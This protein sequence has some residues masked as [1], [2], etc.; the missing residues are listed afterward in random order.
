M[1]YRHRRSVQTLCHHRYAAHCE[2]N[3]SHRQCRLGFLR[4]RLS[5]A[6]D[7]ECGKLVWRTDTVPGDPAQPSIPKPW[8]PAK[9]WH[10]QWWVAGGGGTPWDTIVYDPGL[11]FVYVGTGNGTAWYRDQRSP[12]AATT[13]I[14]PPFSPCAR[15]RGD[16]LTLP[17]NAGRKP[18][19]R[20][21]PALNDGRPQFFRHR[22]Q[23]DHPG[24]EERILLRSRPPTG[25]FLSAK[26][27]VKVT[28]ASGIDPKPGGR[29]N[30]SAYQGQEEVLV[31]PAPGGAHNWY[32][33]A[34]NPATGLVYIPARKGSHALHAPDN[35]WDYQATSWNRGEDPPTTAPWRQMDGETP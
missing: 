8:R 24:V 3:G 25:Q 32:P 28:W 11:D 4:A 21:D 14:S 18:G 33:M 5:P 2:R 15:P 23:G 1:G 10:G 17:G 7:A 26:P 19:L 30:H 13:S 31:S 29:W 34:F 27:F 35:H 9:T 6:Y 12:V 20:R 22:A 16:R